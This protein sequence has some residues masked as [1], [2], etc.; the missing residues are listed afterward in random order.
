MSEEYFLRSGLF[1]NLF[2]SPEVWIAVAYLLCM[3][4]VVTFRPQQ[5]AEPMMFRLSYILFALYFIVPSSINGLLS[6]AFMD[7]G[8]NG[9][10][11]MLIVMQITGVFGKILLGLAIV[12][13]LG[14]LR[15]RLRE[16]PPIPPPDR[17]P[18]QV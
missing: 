11:T 5:I 2:S 16:I 18:P 3:F 1:Q 13:G 8:R 12:F 17:Y 9:G 10:S 15:R 14:S 6:L 4:A 7:S